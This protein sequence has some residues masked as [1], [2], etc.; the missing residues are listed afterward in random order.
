MIPLKN[1]SAHFF[2]QFMDKV[3]DVKYNKGLYEKICDNSTHNASYYG[4]YQSV[5]DKGST[6]HLSVIAP[7]GDTVSV[8]GSV[9]YQ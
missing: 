8:T 7:N 6:S 4:G 9:N 2:Q 1:L 3:L 5:E